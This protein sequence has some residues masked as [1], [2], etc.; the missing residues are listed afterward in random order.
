MNDISSDYEFAEILL[1]LAKDIDFYEFADNDLN[2]SDVYYSNVNSIISDLT[3]HNKGYIRD[4]LLE[5]KDTIT[6]NYTKDDSEYVHY[7]TKI[8]ILEGYL[9]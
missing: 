8:N 9:D 2:E 5:L 6:N 7:M 3:N 1:Q 4:W